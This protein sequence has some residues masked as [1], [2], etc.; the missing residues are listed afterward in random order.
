MQSH[1]HALWSFTHKFENTKALQHTFIGLKKGES[2]KPPWDDL[3]AF[4]LIVSQKKIIELNKMSLKPN[5]SY[6][7]P[8]DNGHSS[9]Q[10]N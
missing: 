2:T 8:L 6:V 7:I 4:L 10:F 1:K 3:A 5:M 9:V